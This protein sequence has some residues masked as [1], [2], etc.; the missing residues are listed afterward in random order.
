MYIKIETLRLSY[1]HYIQDVIH[2]EAYQE[3]VDS[4]LGGETHGSRVGQTMILPA[5]FIGG[6]RGMHKRYMEAL[7]LV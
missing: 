6:L 2:A 7:T 5:L 1:F 3:I 4:V